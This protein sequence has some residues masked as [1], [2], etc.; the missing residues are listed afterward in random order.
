[1]VDYV[2]S[3]LGLIVGVG[4]PSESDPG[5]RLRSFNEIPEVGWFSN[6][7]GVVRINVRIEDADFEAMNIEVGD[8]MRCLAGGVEIEAVPVIS[9]SGPTTLGSMTYYA[10]NGQQVYLPRASW[11]EPAKP[12]RFEI[13]KAGDDS[14]EMFSDLT[15]ADWYDYVYIDTG[16]GFDFYYVHTFDDP[17]SPYS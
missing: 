15:V 4:W 6:D 16:G 5:I 10:V 12:D 1:M 3:P 13:R 14:L 8:T 9:I 17:D 7:N 2:E 11:S